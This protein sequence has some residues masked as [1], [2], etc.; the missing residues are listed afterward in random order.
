MIGYDF[1]YNNKCLRDFGFIMAKPDE[2][3][4]FGLSKS[5]V[6][7]TTNPH[8]S[9][10]LHMGSYYEDVLT[11]NF[12]LIKDVVN[13]KDDF[14]I[15]FD[16]LRNLQTWLTSPKLPQSLYIET[17][18]NK[19]IEYVGLFSDITAVEYNELNGLKATFTCDSPYAFEK[20]IITG[21][22][23]N[24]RR[25]SCNT[26]E[27]DEYIYPIISIKPNSVGTFSIYNKQTDDTLQITT[28]EE[29][30][31]III[32]ERFQR[33]LGDGSPLSFADVGWSVDTVIDYYS[34]ASNAFT[35]PWL[36][37]QPGVNLL[38]F[39]GD[40]KFN[41]TCKVPMKLG[42]FPNV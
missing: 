2:E 34:T 24:V 41:V 37:I 38:T 25:I 30:D 13:D 28:T 20:L 4:N 10:A 9:I 42:G 16:E 12:F 26:D 31:E 19:C 18:D 5:I 23:G 35:I 3:D 39:T 14:K 7:G 21:K 36:R 27:L 33:I 11:L 1:K 32:D 40:A 8:R 29:Y 17:Y 22:N 6:K 15:S